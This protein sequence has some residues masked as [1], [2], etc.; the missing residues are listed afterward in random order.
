MSGAWTHMQ[1]SVCVCVWFLQHFVLA[2]KWDLRDSTNRRM[3]C[4]KSFAVIM[5]LCVGT[6]SCVC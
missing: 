4:K 5:R 1:L 2:G 6:A 3:L